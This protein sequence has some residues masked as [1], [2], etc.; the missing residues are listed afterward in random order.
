MTIGTMTA[1]IS[2]LRTV[3]TYHDARSRGDVPLI[4]DATPWQAV[5]A[6]AGPFRDEAGR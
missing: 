5:M 2:T 1:G 3:R 6:A 4:F